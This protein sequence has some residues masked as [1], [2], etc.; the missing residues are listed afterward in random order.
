MMINWR[1]ILLIAAGVVVVLM[2]AGAATIAWLAGRIDNDQA[3]MILAQRLADLLGREVVISGGFNLELGLNPTITVQQVSVANAA[4]GDKRPMLQLGQVEAT[5][6]LLPMLRRKISV[7]RLKVADAKAWLES[8]SAGRGNW[9]LDGASGGGVPWFYLVDAERVRVDYRDGVKGETHRLQLDR[10]TAVADGREGQVTLS[11]V[12]SL[13]DERFDLGGTFGPLVAVL[14]EGNALALDLSGRYW[15]IRLALKG[16]IIDPRGPRGVNIAVAMTAEDT[17]AFEKPLGLTLPSLGAFRAN[18]RLEDRAG[19]L[20]L[21]GITATIGGRETAQVTLKGDVED[22]LS[23]T[24]SRGLRL[25][26][27]M[28]GPDTALLSETL[29]RPIPALGSFQGVVQVDDRGGTLGLPSIELALGSRDL[30]T[31]VARGSIARPFAARGPEGVGLDLLLEGNALEVLSPAVGMPLPK[32]GVFRISGRFDG[33]MQALTLSRLVARLGSTD[34][35]GEAKIELAGKRP[36]VDARI[37]SAHL[38]ID[39]WQVPESGKPPT[40]RTRVF[41]AN[42]I[43]LEWI[44]V[45]DLSL[46][47][48]AGELRAGGWDATDV[49]LAIA[50]SDGVLTVR[51][52]TAVLYGGRA[53]IE[54][55]ADAR[56]NPP[57]IRAKIAARGLDAA[58]IARDLGSTERLDGRVDATIDLAGRGAS[59]RA[60]AATLNGKL[61]VSL[62]NGRV[63]HRHLELIAADLTRLLLPGAAETETAI[64]CVVTQFDIKAG[65]ATSQVMLADTRRVTVTGTG[66]INLGTEALAL[67]LEPRPKEPSL[68]SLAHPMLVG[69]TLMA[70]TVRP[71]PVGIAKSLGGAALGLSHGPLGLLVP[72]LNTGTGE[73]HPCAKLVG[74]GR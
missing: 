19:K 45:L 62:A 24:G 69:G 12:G 13:N 5:L 36:S 18:A 32:L 64:G 57:A 14:E 29:G 9:E 61:A 46:R 16:G 7:S 4:W 52:S 68:I 33:S 71:D 6:E 34:L 1:K 35:A 63:A 11:V 67:R 55:E 60:L 28:E 65:V 23:T 2:L 15:G 22:V 70:P 37:E 3:R 38:N 59:A 54:G 20:A 27:T 21:R 47:L 39:E 40:R 72:F 51:P 58:A 53:N 25:E 42:T 74:G 31:V 41:D 73:A 8:D 66:N 30:V 48:K 43:P 49:S 50:L 26:L 10:A 56:A 17:K 44:S